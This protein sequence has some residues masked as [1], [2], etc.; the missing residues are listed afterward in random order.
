MMNIKE[1]FAQL[2][3]KTLKT[4]LVA[5]AI[6]GLSEIME[7]K[8]LRLTSSEES[9]VQ[10]ELPPEPEQPTSQ[11]IRTGRFP[12]EGK[13][14]P[15]DDPNQE[16]VRLDEEPTPIDLATALALAGIENPEI[17]VSM[18]RTVS[19][20]ARQQYAA[21]QILP[22]LNFGTNYDMH[23]GVL[24]Q[25]SGN[26]L[27]VNRSALYV[28]A[29]ANA[30]AAGSVNIPGIQYNLNVGESVF[31]YYQQRQLTEA[32]AHQ[33]EAVRN[34]VLLNVALA[35]TD[36]VRAQ[37]L[38]SA[39]VQSR[40]EANEIV[41]ITSAFAKTGEGRDADA[42]R[43]LSELKLREADLIRAEV[44]V[45]IASAN[46]VQ[47]LSMQTSTKL[48]A[49]DSWLVPHP[50]T[51]DM[52][53]RR[54][55]LAIAVMQRPELHEHQARVAASLTALHNAKFLPFSPQFMFGLSSGLFGGGSN[56]IASNKSYFG[57]P[58]NQDRFGNFDARG[59]M[60]VVAYWSL[61]N[62]G[63]GNKA[64]VKEASSRWQESDLEL[65]RMLNQ[66]QREVIDSQTRTLANFSKINI[67]EKA[68]RTSKLAHEQDI[69]RIRS[70]EGLPIEAL[71]SFRLLR[72][73]RQE[74]INT[75]VE[76][77]QAHMELYVLLGNPPGNLLV[78]PVA[79]EPVPTGEAE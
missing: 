63:I 35:Y 76:Y 68:V 16:I 49:S 37:A 67:R 48:Y 9:S 73:S 4:L 22:N 17:L 46:L 15:Q 47:L 57:A 28:G 45:D 19:A 32:A 26:I 31:R 56:L 69:K 25:A 60:D 30:V 74:Y 75:I 64:L 42:K 14:V 50:A 72:T 70:N 77:N 20:T 55:L 36:L 66:V 8:D 21:V 43:A 33:Q 59:D 44:Q 38:R 6:A 71:D 62:L 24:Q 51:P 2:I 65:L 5:S 12:H 13:I 23:L 78:R 34:L 29:G 40:N 7:A 18:Q 3:R 61:R 39:A 53:S 41:E 79:D 11:T 27:Q 58:A 52:L 54:E 1:D 10:P